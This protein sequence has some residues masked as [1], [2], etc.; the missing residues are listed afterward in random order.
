MSF[1][2]ELSDPGSDDFGLSGSDDGL[3]LGSQDYQDFQDNTGTDSNPIDLAT[4][5]GSTS[6]GP[7][8]GGDF[9]GSLGSLSSLLSSGLQQI[10]G[11]VTPT[12]DQLDPGYN[13]PTNYQTTDSGTSPTIG[14]IP[15]SYLLFG[16]AAVLLLLLIA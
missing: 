14:G 15:Q 5:S 8:S 4:G 11:A 9:L 3:D 6:S 2:D 13:S 16:G 1:L 7:S 10:S 12:I